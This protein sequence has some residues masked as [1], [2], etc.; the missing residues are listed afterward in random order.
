VYLHQGGRY[1]LATG[2]YYG[3]ERDLSPAL[4]R[5]AEQ[6]P[7]R[8]VD[9]PNLYDYEKDA[10]VRHLDPT[11]LLIWDG[12]IDVSFGGLIVA[13]KAK[14]TLEAHASL[15]KGCD[16]IHYYLAASGDS[17]K[18]YRWGVSGGVMGVG[19]FTVGSS[20]E[21]PGPVPPVK[22]GD[23]VGVIFIGSSVGAGPPVGGF[24]GIMAITQ[25]SVGGLGTWYGHPF[26]FDV[27]GLNAFLGNGGVQMTVL[28]ATLTE[29]VEVGKTKV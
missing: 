4:G 20:F 25:Y 7:A 24:G 14:F 19:Y 10:P 9:G 21:R 23:N 11:G 15:V 3:R 8:G 5:W 13:F 18:N 26:T 12:R 16:T 6:D 1:E 22:R 29:T 27:G 28:D 2:L 17:S